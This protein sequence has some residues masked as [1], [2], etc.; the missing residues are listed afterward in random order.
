MYA[1]DFD[2]NT[3]I[4]YLV[5]VPPQIL[6]EFIQAAADAGVEIHPVRDQ[7]HIDF[8]SDPTAPNTQT[9]GDLDDTVTAI[10]DFLESEGWEPRIPAP[11]DRMDPQA[12]ADIL[13]TATMWFEW[14][15]TTVGAF[16][17]GESEAEWQEFARAHPQIFGD[18]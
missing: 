1:P 12:T 6:G 14:D 2:Q 7:V 17:R 3:G 4:T 15:G 16:R 9:G 18:G 13:Y 11:D 8:D 10:N 5:A